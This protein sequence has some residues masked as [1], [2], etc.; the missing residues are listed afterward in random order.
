M[1][2]EHIYIPVIRR[3]VLSG[4]RDS[5]LSVVSASCTVFVDLSFLLAVL[6]MQLSPVSRRR[7]RPYKQRLPPQD[8]ENQQGH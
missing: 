6:A 7:L 8:D 1:G 3:V 5:A 4:A 2:G